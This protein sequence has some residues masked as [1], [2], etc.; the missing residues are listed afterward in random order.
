M[1]SEVECHVCIACGKDFDSENKYEKHYKTY[2]ENNPKECDVC[3]QMF[4][5][6][7]SYYNHKKR[8]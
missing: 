5:T 7:G 1:A 4:S 8:K 3:G 6:I 2:H